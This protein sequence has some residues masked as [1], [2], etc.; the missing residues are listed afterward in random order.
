MC[1][2]TIP[3][4]GENF[5]CF[6]HMLTLIIPETA[7]NIPLFNFDL[8]LSPD[9]T[10]PRAGEEPSILNSL[11]VFFLFRRVQLYIMDLGSA[12]GTFVNNNKV[13]PSKYVQLLEK[14]V[15]KFGFS[16]REY[17][18]LHDQSKEEEEDLGVD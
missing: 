6:I 12:N 8:F 18:L 5:V 13:E 15:L 14:D 3:P 16:S 17:V 1:P 7:S 10:A 4:A 2:L 11:N 9:L